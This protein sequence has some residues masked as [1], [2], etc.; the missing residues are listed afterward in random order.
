[1]H[2][3]SNGLVVGAITPHSGL[4]SKAKRASRKNPDRQGVSGGRC[5]LS[6]HHPRASRRT[7]KF[8]L[9]FLTKTCCRQPVSVG[10]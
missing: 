9:R 3:A 2:K 1:M 4:S 8:A 5:G 6:P 10:V 7:G